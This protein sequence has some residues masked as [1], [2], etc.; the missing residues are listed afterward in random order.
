MNNLLMG[1]NLADHQNKPAPAQSREEGRS[2]LPLQHLINRLCF[3]FERLIMWYKWTT[4]TMQKILQGCWLRSCSCSSAG[5]LQFFATTIFHQ[6]HNEQQAFPFTSA[7]KQTIL[8]K[9]K[10]SIRK[11][12]KHLGEKAEKVLE[13]VVS[14][15]ESQPPPPSQPP[16]PK[17][18]SP[19]PTVS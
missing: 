3:K 8:N 18:K 9:S 11:S 7:P 12:G 15:E 14:L 13:K 16:R 1:S 5:R 10:G 17:N 6:L 2:S 19:R 4:V